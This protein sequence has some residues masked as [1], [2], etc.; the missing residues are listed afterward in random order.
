MQTCSR[1]RANEPS[2]KLRSYKLAL[3]SKWKSSNWSLWQTSFPLSALV[4]S[5]ISWHILTNNKHFRILKTKFLF[6]VV[7]SWAREVKSQ[8]KD[9]P[10]YKYHRKET[11]EEKGISES[12]SE[13]TDGGEIRMKYINYYDTPEKVG[14]SQRETNLF[15]AVNPQLKIWKD[16]VPP[17]ISRSDK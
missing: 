2:V 12:R 14:R 5:F 10:F 3:I 4:P 9:R 11:A 15:L 1:F 16:F 17:R 6:F 8:W 13:K 7:P